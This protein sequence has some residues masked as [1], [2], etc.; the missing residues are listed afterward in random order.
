[1]D[2][3]RFF[4]AKYRSSIFSFWVIDFEMWLRKIIVCH[5]EF[6]QVTYCFV[7]ENRIDKAKDLVYHVR[8]LINKIQ[9][10][11]INDVARIS[12]DIVIVVQIVFHCNTIML[13]IKL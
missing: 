9:R 8:R 2:Q 6:E 13:T 1:M 7:G 12:L 10:E 5:F 4:Y 11:F 3:V